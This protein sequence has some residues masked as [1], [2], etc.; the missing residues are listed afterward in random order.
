VPVNVT[1]RRLVPSPGRS[2]VRL[3]GH[4]QLAG[5]RLDTSRLPTD[6]RHMS[7]S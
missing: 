2:I 7:A 5:I 6:A 4:R 3:S 1:Q